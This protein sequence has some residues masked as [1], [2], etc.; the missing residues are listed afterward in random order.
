MAKFTPKFQMFRPQNKGA[1]PDAYGGRELR[2]WAAWGGAEYA[3]LYVEY[4]RS[5]YCLLLLMLLLIG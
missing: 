5:A 1:V 3:V 4:A 2:R